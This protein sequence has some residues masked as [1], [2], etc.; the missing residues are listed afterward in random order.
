MCGEVGSLPR[1]VRPASVEGP[2]VRAQL[3][4]VSAEPAANRCPGDMC[5][6][7]GSLPRVVV[8]ASGDMCS[9]VKSLHRVVMPSSDG[10]GFSRAGR[11]R[12]LRWHGASLSCYLGGG[13]GCGDGG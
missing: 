1:V 11:E 9:E 4:V 13:R 2:S 8:P 10:Y 6:E 3:T 5:S 12:V 7:V